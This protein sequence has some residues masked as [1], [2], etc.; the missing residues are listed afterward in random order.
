MTDYVTFGEWGSDSARQ[1]GNNLLTLMARIKYMKIRLLP[2]DLSLAFV[3]YL[4]EK[5]NGHMTCHIING[6]VL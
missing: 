2:C 1:F 3:T 6:L 4:K 5:K